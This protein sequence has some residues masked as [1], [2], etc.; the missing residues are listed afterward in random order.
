M[1]ALSRSSFFANTKKEANSADIIFWDGSKERY[2][3][4]DV[5]VD[6]NCQFVAG[7]VARI[8]DKVYTLLGEKCKTGGSKWHLRR[9]DLAGG[10]GVD[11]LNG[12][13]GSKGSALYFNNAASNDIMAL[14]GG[15]D[16]LISVPNGLNSN[17]VD[18]AR[19]TLGD[20]PA[21]TTVQTSVVSDIYPPASPR[22]LL[23]SPN[24]QRLAMVSLAGGGSE[25]LWLYDMTQPDSKPIGVAGGNAS[26]RITGVAWSADGSKLFYTING[27]DNGLLYSDPNGQIKR[28]ARGVFQG[29][30][31]SA[32]GNT[33]ITSEKVEA[34][35]NDIRYNLVQVNVADQSKVNLVE[36]AKGEQAITP[37][38]VR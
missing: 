3:E 30:A 20:S 15:N 32:D 14:P 28:V 33:A 7:R 19:V 2:I 36:G 27:E 35:K 5:K 9:T 4:Q 17:V 24:G 12:S 22:R 10:T 26:D 21:L 31:V 16:I 29:L 25:K 18:L 34:A 8:N 23:R 38:V 6:E 37:L 13:T 11:L 1:M